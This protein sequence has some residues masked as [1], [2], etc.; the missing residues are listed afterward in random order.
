M[1]QLSIMEMILHH[2]IL[3]EG[4]GDS[5]LQMAK[6]YAVDVV[7]LTP[8]ANLDLQI[9]YAEQYTIDNA[10]ELKMKASQVPLGHAQVFVIIAEGILNAAQN[11]LLKLFEEPAK[12]T[13]FVIVVPER[14]K[15]I[16]TMLSRLT[17][18]GSAHSEAVSKNTA[19][20]FLQATIQERLKIIRPLIENKKRAEARRLLTAIENE[21][22]ENGVQEHAKALR[23]VAF[24]RQYITDSSSS[25]KMLL[26]HLA[27]TI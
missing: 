26:E 12:N 19:D 11:A 23:E 5:A 9:I 13:Y 27:V 16:P 8:G 7:G 24:V 10:R 21:L 15:L 20:L 25:L 22:H 2:A 4:E 14:N 17:F 1:V 18:G 6:R 3:I